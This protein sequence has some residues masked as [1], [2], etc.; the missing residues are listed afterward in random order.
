MKT[1][2]TF[3]AVKHHQKIIERGLKNDE[4]SFIEIV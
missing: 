2:F 3:I 4:Q 1:C